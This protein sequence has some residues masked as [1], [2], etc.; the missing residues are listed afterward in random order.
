[1]GLS[2]EEISEGIRKVEPVEHRLNVIEAV[3]GVIIIDDAF[4]SNPIGTKAALEVLGEFKEG[5]K[6]VITPGM[7]EL[8]DMEE[9]A[10]REFGVNMA[11][12]C[13]YVILIGEKRTM[14]IYEGLI[15]TG[16]NPSNVFRVHNLNEATAQLGKLTKPKDVVLF[17]NDLPD[18][19]S[20]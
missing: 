13:D 16:F 1:M 7:I 10:N 2:F 18:N 3:N 4:N 14:P 9:S 20:E 6:I 5:N 17:E 8:G 11:K 12:V 15:S 19:Y